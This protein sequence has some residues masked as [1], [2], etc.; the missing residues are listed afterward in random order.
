MSITATNSSS[1]ILRTTGLKADRAMG[2]A[3]LRLATGSKINQ[4]SDDAAG[5][6]NATGFM[7]QVSS[8]AVAVRNTNDYISLL[9]IADGAAS[10]IVNAL[11][12]VRELAVQS[13]NGTLSGSNRQA[14]DLEGSQ[15]KSHIDAIASQTQFNGINL[16]DGSFVS[17]NFQIGINSNDSISLTVPSLRIKNASQLP[18]VAISQGVSYA[19][20]IAGHTAITT[21]NV[22]GLMKAGDT[23]SIGGLIFNCNQDFT[24]TSYSG[25]SLQPYRDVAWLLSTIDHGATNAIYQ[26]NSAGITKGVFSGDLVGWYRNGTSVTTD[27]ANSRLWSSTPNQIV[28]DLTVTTNS[29]TMTMNVERTP[30]NAPVP[31]ILAATESANIGFTGLDTGESVT[32]A[33]LKFTAGRNTTAAEVANAFSNLTN[34][35]THGAADYGNYSGSLNGYSSGSANGS[36]VTM[37]SAVTDTNVSDISVT[38]NTGIQDFSLATQDSSVRA[39]GQIDSSLEF[40]QSIQSRIAA[41]VNRAVSVADNLSNTSLN[42]SASYSNINDTDYSVESSNLASQNIIRQATTALQAQA[43]TSS[44]Y[45]LA[46][47]R[48]FMGGS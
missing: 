44:K 19:P 17:K 47:L 23:L 9:Q 25:G 40:V 36:N 39:I 5:L 28:P 8:M 1:E 21:L 20:A 7:T 10:Q 43:N 18:T 16:F 6:A 35:D 22:S 15:L 27:S 26:F 37:I 38:V 24:T 13:S 12:R 29:S 3:M 32:V 41:N 45:V 2:Q 33:G 30:G 34:A 31:E 46:L 11:Q 14:I 42:L 48:Q 4:A